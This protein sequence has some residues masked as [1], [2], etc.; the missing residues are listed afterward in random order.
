MI[1]KQAEDKQ[2]DIDILLKAHTPVQFDWRKRFGHTHS[3]WGR[4]YQTHAAALRRPQSLSPSAN[5]DRQS[6]LQGARKME[7]AV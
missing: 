4:H 1:L 6:D 3:A 2:G 7:R 5:R